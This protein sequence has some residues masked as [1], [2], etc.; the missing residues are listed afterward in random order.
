MVAAASQGM[1]QGCLNCCILLCVA[2]PAAM[3][4]VSTHMAACSYVLVLRVGYEYGVR[5]VDAAAH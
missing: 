1:Q 3:F 5:V 2:V 4:D